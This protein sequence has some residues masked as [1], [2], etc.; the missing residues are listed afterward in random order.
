MS[1]AALVCKAN[2]SPAGRRKRTRFGTLWLVVSVAAFVLLV[3]LRAPPYV[4]L[5]M[6]IPASLSAV[7]LLQARRN[8][9][10]M[11]AQ[12]GTFENE[13]FS[14]VKAADDEVAAS[15]KVAA[16]INRDVILIGIAGAAIAVAV[17][18]LMR[19]L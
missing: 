16:R 7:G 13:D 18:T 14:T 10:I 4:G 17:A 9:C 5:L 6:F 15:R 3:V 11:R 8:T 12:E 2:I 19:T 1:D